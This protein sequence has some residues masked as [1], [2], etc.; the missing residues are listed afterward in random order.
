MADR[1]AR[2]RGLFS[3]LCSGACGPR[4]PAP[5]GGRGGGGCAGR[6][7]GARAGLAAGPPL[8]GAGRGSPVE[9]GCARF[10]AAGADGLAGAGGAGTFED[11]SVRRDGAVRGGAPAGADVAGRFGRAAGSCAPHRAQN[12]NVAAFS[13]A[14]AGHCLGAPAA[15]RGFAVGAAGPAV[16][17]VASGDP[18]DWQD[19]APPSVSAPQRGQAMP[20]VVSFAPKRG[21]GTAR[22]GV[23]GNWR[24]PRFCGILVLREG[25]CRRRR[26]P[27]KAVPGVRARSRLGRRSSASFAEPRS[28]PPTAPSPPRDSADA[29]CGI[30]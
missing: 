30:R 24:N 29:R 11:G 13:V 25:R 23:F 3:G 9:A 8:G 22:A 20:Q 4:A 16:F 26:R 17:G 14:H 5:T 21:Q 27:H 7:D 19:A 2:G 18:H 1:R 28:L 6:P 10:V 15:S 12:L